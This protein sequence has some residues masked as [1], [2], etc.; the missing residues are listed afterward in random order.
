MRKLPLILLVSIVIVLQSCDY[1]KQ[2][3]GIGKYSLKAAIEWAKADSTRVADSLKK[4]A[5]EKNAF[6]Q[7]LTDSIQ[8]VVKEGASKKAAVKETSA[9]NDH[10][11]LYYIVA[12][13]FSSRDNANAA[14]AKYNSI[15]FK[16]SVIPGKKRSGNGVLL[17]T[18]KSF[19][20]PNQAH[21][22]LIDFKEKYDP[23]A[24]LYSVK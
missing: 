6:K 18:I 22:F 11:P 20:D 23:G 14:V 7:A 13:S 12:G 19:N 1:L 9:K 10:D 24:W 16:A 17:V 21:V 2:R 8:V 5:A 15:G 3:L 4:V